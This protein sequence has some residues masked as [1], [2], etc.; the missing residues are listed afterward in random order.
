MAPQ[1][2]HDMLPPGSG[3]SLNRKTGSAAGNTK[4]QQHS[5]YAGNPHRKVLAAR[6]I[7]PRDDTRGQPLSTRVYLP[8]NKCI[9]YYATL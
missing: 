6:S 2:Q 4:K 7:P 1:R 5:K 9:N 3:S 8:A